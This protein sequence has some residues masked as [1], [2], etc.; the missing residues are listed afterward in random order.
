M[1]KLRCICPNFLRFK[2]KSGKKRVNPNG[3]GHRVLLNESL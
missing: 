2:H 3:Q 1:L